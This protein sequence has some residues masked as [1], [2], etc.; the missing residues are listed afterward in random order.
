MKT[1]FTER[2]DFSSAEG[3]IDGC[4]KN[5][6][7]VAS[8]WAPLQK[9]ISGVR[10]KEIK[11][12]PKEN[13]FLTEIFRTDWALDEAQVNQVFQVVLSAGE[14]SAWHAHQFTTDRLFGSY[15][16]LKIV[17]FDA[18]TSSPTYRLINE[19]RIGLIRPSLIVVPPGV[20][21]GIQNIAKESSCLINLV[22]RAYDYE[23]PDH[24]ELPSDTKDIPYSFA[25]T[26]PV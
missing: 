7:S 1:L 8:D 6:R 25:N 17:L 5:E 10:V 14:V 15:G 21:H 20:W 2:T 3:S 4:T 16:L 22:D 13:G 18:R 26:T 23:D 19:F 11:N 12:V 24:W 9:L